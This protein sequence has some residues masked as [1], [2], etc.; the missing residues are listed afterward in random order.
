MRL[1]R[2]DEISGDFLCTSAILGKERACPPKVEDVIGILG[3][4]WI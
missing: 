1:L 4:A 3:T 2:A